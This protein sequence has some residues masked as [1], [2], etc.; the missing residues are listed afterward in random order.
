MGM[1]LYNSPEQLAALPR[2]AAS[3]RPAMAKAQADQNY[4]GWK[5]A[6]QSVIGPESGQ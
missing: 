1:G 4:A 6:V 3:Y 2:R 5:R